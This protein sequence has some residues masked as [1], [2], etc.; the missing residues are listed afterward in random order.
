MIPL[1]VESINKGNSKNYSKLSTVVT[2]S[3]AKDFKRR[4]SSLCS[5]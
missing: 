3:I 1:W 2:L 5:E 4:D